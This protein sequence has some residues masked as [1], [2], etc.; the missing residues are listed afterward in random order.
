MITYTVKE[1]YR[2]LKLGIWTSGIV[3]GWGFVQSIRVYADGTTNK[4]CFV[5]K[6]PKEY[7]EELQQSKQQ[8]S[9]GL[10]LLDL[11]QLEE[12]QASKNNNKYKI[13]TYMA[14]VSLCR[15]RGAYKEELFYLKVTNNEIFDTFRNRLCS[16]ENLNRAANNNYFTYR[17]N[18]NRRKSTIDTSP[19]N[20]ATRKY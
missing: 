8:L 18:K 9:I 16:R 10:Q 1:F 14:I 6:M 4:G 11:H 12:Q 5:P 20:S 15:L 13:Y 2:Y 3:D 19:I 17:R 7:K